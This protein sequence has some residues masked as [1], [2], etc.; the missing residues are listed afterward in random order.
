MV[1]SALGRVMYDAVRD[2]ALNFSIVLELLRSTEYFRDG[3]KIFFSMTW[4]KAFGFMI[5]SNGL[6]SYT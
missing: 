6:R 5:S 3:L 4:T 2:S 1:G